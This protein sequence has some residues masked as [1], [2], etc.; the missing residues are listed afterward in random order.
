MKEPTGAFD[1]LEHGHHAM[2]IGGIPALAVSIS[3]VASS[4]SS[5]SFNPNAQRFVPPP[6][7]WHPIATLL[8]VA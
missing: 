5:L 2:Y 8:G 7:F 3:G 4:M 1:L 6:S